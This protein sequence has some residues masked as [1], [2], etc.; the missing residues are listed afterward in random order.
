MNEPRKK[1]ELVNYDFCFGSGSNW[2][3]LNT[4]RMYHIQEY[5]EALDR[6]EHPKGIRVTQGD[7]ISKTIEWVDPVIARER[8][9][10]PEPDPRF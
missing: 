6:G 3:D 4:G 8:M 9:K 7:D 1:H 5:K 10:D 2:Y